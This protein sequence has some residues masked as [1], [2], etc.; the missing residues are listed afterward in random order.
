MGD[1]ATTTKRTPA[2]KRS[3][4]RSLEP[5]AWLLFSADG[6]TAALPIPVL[7]VLLALFHWAHRFR[8]A[9]YHGLRLERAGGVVVVLCYGGAVVG[10][11]VAAYVLISAW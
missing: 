4:P 7:R 8:F 2:P 6:M 9:L 3:T 1:L 5:A 11:V 10:S